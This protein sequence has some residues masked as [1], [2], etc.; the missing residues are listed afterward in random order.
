MKYR[1]RIGTTHPMALPT[2]ALVGITDTNALASRACNAA[3]NSVA[4]NLFAGLAV[5]GRS[6]TYVSAHVPG[7]LSRHLADVAKGHP[8]SDPPGSRTGLVGRHHAPGAGGRPG[9]RRLPAPSYPGSQAS[10]PGPALRLRGDPDDLGTA[11]LAEFLAPAVIISA[12]SVFTRFGLAN[13]VADTWLPLAHRAAAS[14]RLRGDPHRGG[15]RP[16]TGSP[17][18]RRAGQRS[19]RRSPPPPAGRTRDRRGHRPGRVSGRV[20]QARPAAG[21]GPGDPRVAA[22][23]IEAFGTLPTPT[24]RHARLCG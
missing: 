19:R 12:D 7:E 3:R 11:A 14:S 24:A 4:E 8:G 23:G 9:G 10:R 21:S 1:P 16:R 13:S 5:T 20:P 15:I 17:A 6:N 2:P 22:T 18:G